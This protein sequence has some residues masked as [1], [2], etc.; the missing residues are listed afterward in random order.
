MEAGEIGVDYVMFG[1]PRPD[2]SLMPFSALLDRASWWAQLFETPCVA[3]APTPESVE[4]LAWTR[5]EFIALGPWCF[6]DPE[7]AAET[8]RRARANAEAQ[9]G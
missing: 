9:P 2:G 4:K 8:V 7:A 3:Y 5:A 6:E 1:E